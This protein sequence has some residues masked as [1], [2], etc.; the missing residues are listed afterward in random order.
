MAQFLPDTD[1]EDELDNNWEER[2]NLDG[3][4]YYVNHKTR[5]WVVIDFFNILSNNKSKWFFFKIK[6]STQWLHPK[7]GK[8]KKL[9]G[10]LPINWQ[11][12]I[13]DDGTITY[14]K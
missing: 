11:E 13:A 6:I 12:Q 2:A 9:S 8:R 14:V 4:V 10:K 3:Q 7:T 1:S 5:R